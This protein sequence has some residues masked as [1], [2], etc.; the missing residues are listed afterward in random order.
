MVPAGMDRADYHKS[1]LHPSYGDKVDI[2]TNKAGALSYGNLRNSG[3]HPVDVGTPAR[4]QEA[5][6]PPM[7][8][9]DSDPHGLAH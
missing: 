9:G 3:M 4:S 1:Y 8:D 2:S 7:D 5:S 6:V